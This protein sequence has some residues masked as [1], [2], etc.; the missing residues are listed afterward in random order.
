MDSIGRII[1]VN[2]TLDDNVH[3]MVDSSLIV[4]FAQ[5]LPV[6][7]FFLKKRSVIVKGII[8]K[9]FS[10]NNVRFQ[11]LSNIKRSGAVKDLIAALIEFYILVFKGNKSSLFVFSYA[12]MFSRYLINFGSKLTGKKVLIC[13]HSELE[14][15]VTH[16]LKG[17]GYWE[18]LMGLFYQLNLAR[19]LR[20]VVLGDSIQIELQKHVPARVNDK[21]ISLIHPYFHFEAPKRKQLSSDIIHIGVVGVVSMSVHRGYDNLMSFTSKIGTYGNVKI[22]IISRIDK[23]L[24]RELPQSVIIENPTGRYLPKDEYE[25]LIRQMDYLYYPYPKDAFKLTASGAIFESVA[26]QRP[27]LMYSNQFFLYLTKEYGNFGL[28]VDQLSDDMF[29]NMISDNNNYNKMCDM[30]A[31]FAT[32]VNPIYLSDVLYNKISDSYAH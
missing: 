12:N 31:G 26:N 8:D 6:D 29:L 5:K 32:Q 14:S 7:V 18:K 13:A 2:A 4:A 27:P 28:F 25:Q 10:L 22:H 16:K 19:K 15:I 21:V 17:A 23:E 30:L 3:E 9:A 1:F 20:I 11:P 24:Q